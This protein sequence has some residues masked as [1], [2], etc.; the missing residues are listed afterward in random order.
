MALIGIQCSKQSKVLN[1][2]FTP[3]ADSVSLSKWRND[4]TGCLN[5]RN[6]LV[7]SNKLNVKLLMAAD[8]NQVLNS[9]GGPNI[10][11]Y[12]K[13]Y[14]YYYY[15]LSCSKAPKDKL[16]DSIMRIKSSDVAMLCFKFDKQGIVV[17]VLQQ[18]P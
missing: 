1:I 6:E 10:I 11:F 14:I 5:L 15:Y 7:N 18:I 2:K 4:S 16:G 13:E 9:I 8:T 3:V 12:K 17:D